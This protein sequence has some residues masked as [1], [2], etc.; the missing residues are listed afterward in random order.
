[1][2]AVKQKVLIVE[3]DLDVADLLKTY[4]RSEGYD[5]FA[6]SRGENG[7]LVCQTTFPDVI[8]LDIRLP[9][10]NG[11]EVARRLRSNRR[12]ADIP[13]VFLTEKRERSERLQGLELGAVDY[14]PKPFDVQELGLRIRNALKRADRD[15]LTNPITGLPDGKLVDE[16]IIDN[17][18]RLNWG[19]LVITIENLDIFR[20]I[21]GFVASDDVL[22]AVGLMVKNALKEF[23]QK[24]DFLGHLGPADFIVISSK[25]CLLL[26][27]ERIFGR[28]E[29]SLEYF[30]PIK[31]REKSEARAKPLFVRTRLIE[32]GDEQFT[33]VNDLK[34]S[35]KRIN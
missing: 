9:D 4:F 12:T 5:V 1:M 31:D 32:C 2:A 35:L 17:L 29:Q 18:G 21:Y 26:L 23:G 33:S 13:I 19:I 24:D 7:V 22:R 3:D 11:Y 10:I 20:E 14:V 8:I 25:E 16:R 27:R 15:S 30:Y 6:T 34:N 28:L